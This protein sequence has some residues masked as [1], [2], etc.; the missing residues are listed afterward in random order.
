MSS[1]GNDDDDNNTQTP[2]TICP[3]N[4]DVLPLTQY[5][6]Y[7]QKTVEELSFSKNEN[8]ADSWRM[9]LNREPPSE[10]KS[11]AKPEKRVQLR[12]QKR[13]QSYPK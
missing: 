9:F 13:L 8:L 4:Y 12:L 1:N 10:I 2:Q 6:R 11:G 3:G 7:Q 5:A